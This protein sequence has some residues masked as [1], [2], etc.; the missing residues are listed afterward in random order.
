MRYRNGPDIQPTAAE[1]DPKQHWPKN[2]QPCKLSPAHPS[3]SKPKHAHCPV[4][5]RSSLNAT[6]DHDPAR[7]CP[8]PTHIMRKPRALNPT[9]TTPSHVCICSRL[10]APCRPIHPSPAVNPIAHM[11][12]PNPYS[13][14]QLRTA[15]E[16]DAIY[17]YIWCFCVPSCCAARGSRRPLDNKKK[18][19]KKS[20]AP[21]IRS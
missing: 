7:A 12:R 21:V 5:G 19:E 6:Q 11:P 3:L 4:V 14:Q 20:P 18:K 15:P 16:P 9:E 8:S 17:M 2:Q 1:K 13:C 10:P